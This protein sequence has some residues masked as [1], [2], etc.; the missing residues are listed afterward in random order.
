M[1]KQGKEVE[2]PRP[3]VRNEGEEETPLEEKSGEV[4]LRA[5]GTIGEPEVEEG[6]FSFQTSG[7]K[8][9]SPTMLGIPIHT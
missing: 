9:S 3:E 8:K 4:P 1:A 2:E 7:R 6:K 5:V